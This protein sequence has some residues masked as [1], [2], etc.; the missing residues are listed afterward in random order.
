M[1]IDFPNS[2]T[3][4]DKFTSGYKTWIF[5]GTVW[6][7]AFSDASIT[8]N[9]VNTTALVD[10]SVTA[11][12]LASNS[13]TTAKITDANVTA[14]KLATD[15]VTT[16]KILDLNVT[17]GKLAADSVAT[18][19]IVNSAVTTAKIADKSV[20]SAK[21]SAIT[22]TAQT[23]AYTFVLGDAET[24][25]LY[26]G[27]SPATFTIPTN[28]SVAFPLGTQINVMQYSSGQLTVACAAGATLVSE[29]SKFKTKAIYAIATAIKTETNVW[30]LV[31]NLAA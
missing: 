3:V 1:A 6:G 25:I 5:D 11:A 22:S 8:S 21:I 23:T 4:G 10:G 7:L 18:A 16:A 29:G 12:K 20:T 19:K 13:V 9:S 2:P 24:L 26:T 17:S 15:S 30:V 27:A 31:G 28:S 14:A